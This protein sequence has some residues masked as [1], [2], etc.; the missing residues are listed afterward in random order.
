MTPTRWSV[1]LAALAAAFTVPAQGAPMPSVSAASG[2]RA[3]LSADGAY[4]VEQR[5]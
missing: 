2:L 1:A 5:G 4:R 3:S